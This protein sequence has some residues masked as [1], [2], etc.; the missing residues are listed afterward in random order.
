MVV[1]FGGDDGGDDGGSVGG[2][3][4][5]IIDFPIQG[6]QFVYTAT[7]QRYLELGFASS[8][9]VQLGV[10]PVVKSWF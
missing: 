9:F 6:Y 2:A 5:D 10:L 4:G 8:V 1:V 7:S 3:V